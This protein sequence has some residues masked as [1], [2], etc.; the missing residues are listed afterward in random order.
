MSEKEFDQAIQIGCDL[1]DDC[2]AEGCRILSIGEMG[3]ANTSPS[4]IWMHLF[5]GIP[6]E[7][8]IGAGAGLDTPGIRHKYEVLSNAL[9]NYQANTHHPTPI[10]HHPTPSPQPPTLLLTSLPTA[11]VL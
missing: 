10:T 9:A 2:I 1:V 6:L 8:C 5:T 3:I 4:S 7:D 11:T